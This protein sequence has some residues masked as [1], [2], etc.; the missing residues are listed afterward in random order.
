MASKARSKTRDRLIRAA[1][2]LFAQRGVNGV[3]ANAILRAA[4][5]ANRS[6]I[7]YHFGSREGLLRAVLEDIARRLQPLQAEML[8]E[9]ARL[10]R[11]RALTAEELINAAHLPFMQFIIAEPQGRAAAKLLSRLTWEYGAVGQ[12]LLV[13]IFV[14]YLAALE[15]RLAAALPH[16][17]RGETR[18]HFILSAES[19][20]H[21]L[22]D[23]GV[24]DY[25]PPL[26]EAERL[27][28]SPYQLLESY[29]A[30]QHYGVLG[31]PPAVSVKKS[32]S[33]ETSAAA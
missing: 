8:A 14:P 3:S 25:L 22:S 26:P 15:M 30:F 9:L 13:E 24:L 16:K 1:L 10:E 27:I 33:A 4:R 6:A 7:R 23:I 28:A 32:R 11:T 17:P 18:L 21:A 5:A 12:K 20:F 31:R 19:L 2:E 29:L